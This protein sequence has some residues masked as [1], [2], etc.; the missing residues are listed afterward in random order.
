MEFADVVRTRR[1]CRRYDP[2][3]TVSD[4]TIGRLLELSGR[5]PSA[6]FT[7]GR[8]VVVLRDRRSVDDFWELSTRHRRTSGDRP[9]AE[10]RAGADRWLR[11]MR[12]APVLMLWLSDPQRYLERYSLPDKGGVRAGESGWPIPYW[13]VDA[14]MAA[15]IVM[16]AAQDAGLGSCF[17]GVQ[18]GAEED[19]RERFGIPPGH[20]LV[21]VTSVG[22]PAPP[23]GPAERA[24]PAGRAVT[25]AAN[26]YRPRKRPVGDFAHA[27]RFGSGWPG[28]DPGDGG[29]AG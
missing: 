25:A 22:H 6:G 18:A 11:G 23:S 12:T 10:D 13:D 14:G 21:G 26:P 28:P 16:L 19:L 20:R 5:A 29:R 3:R 7:Q 4:E 15:L 17:F 8:D 9:E 1:M 27:E 24:D 2:E